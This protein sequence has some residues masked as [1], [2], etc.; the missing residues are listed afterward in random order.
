[1]ALSTA[2]FVGG[3]EAW[4]DELVK[5]ASSL[6]VNSGAANDSDLGPVISRQVCF[7]THVCMLILLY[8]PFFGSM[9]FVLVHMGT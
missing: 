4:E 7:Q 1:M 3:S 8:L 6:V 2:V 9:D 5:R